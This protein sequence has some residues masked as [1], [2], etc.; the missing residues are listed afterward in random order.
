MDLA[1]FSWLNPPAA[2]RPAGNAADFRTLPRTDFWQRTHYGFR[3]DDGHLLFAPWTGDFVLEATVA[4]AP[5]AKYDQAGLMVR[6]SPSCWL[7]TSCEF[8][9]EGPSQLGA[10]VTNTGFSDWS[11]R[12]VFPYPGRIRL[13]IE[14]HGGDYLLAARIGDQGPMD[15]HRVARLLEDDSRGPLMVGLY[16]CSPDGDGCDV[17]F[18]E[19]ILDPRG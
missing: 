2:L 19:V 6:C 16:A 5:N 18:S 12:P 17:A 10:V 15:V 14:R 3:R 4:L 1:G 7:K 8:Q 11:Y 9:P 13:R